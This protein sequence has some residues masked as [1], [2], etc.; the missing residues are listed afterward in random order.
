MID[1]TLIQRREKLAALAERG[2]D[3]ERDNARR[4]LEEFDRKHPE[5][6]QRAADRSRVGSDFVDIDF[7]QLVN[8]TPE[9]LQDIISIVFDRSASD[10]A[11]RIA[12]IL[13]K[14]RERRQ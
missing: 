2:I 11:R 8:L 9:D 5:V 3:G 10:R 7:G 1:P 13:K 14:M 4:M 6:K 12:S